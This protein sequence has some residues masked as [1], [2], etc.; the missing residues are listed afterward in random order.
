MIYN[1]WCK[2][3]TINAIPIDAVA[4][5]AEESL[6][7]AGVCGCCGAASCD[8]LWQSWNSVSSDGG[9]ET[10]NAV[11]APDPADDARG[12]SAG[13][14][15]LGGGGDPV[16][17]GVDDLVPS[18]SI[19]ETLNDVNDE[20]NNNNFNMMIQM[21]LLSLGLCFGDLR[22]SKFV[23]C[24]FAAIWLVACNNAE[25]SAIP[26]TIST[27]TIAMRADN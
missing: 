3:T 2:Q 15:V 19:D 13:G 5:V 14:A 10:L 18:G 9:D 17:G 11:N 8:E 20:H 4:V 22:E 23:W 16:A 1:N 27:A 7:S 12:A 25:M 24:W 21:I 6:A 26:L